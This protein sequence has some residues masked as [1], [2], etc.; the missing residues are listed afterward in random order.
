ML[1]KD[2]ES[3]VEDVKAAGLVIDCTLEDT[4]GASLEV[5]DTEITSAPE[6]TSE[7]NMVVPVD[8]DDCVDGVAN[9]IEE[10]TG[11]APKVADEEVAIK[12]SR[13]ELDEI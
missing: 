12:E 2:V 8:N 4:S 10:S 7:N 9:I 6:D 11:V 5:A 3:I 13:S 1:E